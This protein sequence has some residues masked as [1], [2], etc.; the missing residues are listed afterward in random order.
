M[1]QEDDTLEKGTLQVVQEGQ[2]AK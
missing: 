1:V 2:R